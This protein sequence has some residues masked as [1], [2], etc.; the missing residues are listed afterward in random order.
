MYMTLNNGTVKIGGRM[1]RLGYT[2]NTSWLTR[3]TDTVA[4]WQERSRS[5]RALAQ[6][7]SHQLS[8]IGVNRLDAI[9]EASKPFWRA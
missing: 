1:A 6:L 3:L 9:R 4:M 5:R 7:T 2:S 8:D